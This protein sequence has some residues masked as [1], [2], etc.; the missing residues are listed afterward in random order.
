MNSNKLQIYFKFK[1]YYIILNIE[2]NNIEHF[3]N[4]K[5]IT[6][7]KMDRLRKDYKST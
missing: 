6:H 1:L 3:T 2:I 7:L 4:R 5:L